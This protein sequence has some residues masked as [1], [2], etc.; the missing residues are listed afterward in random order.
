MKKKTKELKKK[1]KRVIIYRNDLEEINS[2]LLEHSE[3]ISYETDNYLFD[4]F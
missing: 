2:I 3:S 1:Y 4:R